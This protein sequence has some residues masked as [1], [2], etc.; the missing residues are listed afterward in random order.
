MI[1]ENYDL[2]KQ[3]EINIDFIQAEPIIFINRPTAETEQLAPLSRCR[4]HSVNKYKHPTTTNL[5][6]VVG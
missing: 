6:V 4:E 2:E 5:F 1:T 3:A